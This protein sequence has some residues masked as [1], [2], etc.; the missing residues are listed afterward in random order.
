M[1]ATARGLLVQSN[2]KLGGSAFHFDLPPVR[3]CPGRSKLCEGVCYA[4]TGR[5]RFPQVRERL[6]WAFEQSRRADFVGRM[7]DELYRKGVLLMR[8]HVAGDFYSP[9]Y[10]KKARAVVEALSGVRFWAYTRSWRVPKLAD[11]LWGIAELDNFA[12]WLSADDETGYPPYVPDGVRVAWMQ[13]DESPEQADLVFAT[14]EVRKQPA[15]INL[16]LLCP[17]ETDAG[18]RAGTT[19]SSCQYC[20]SK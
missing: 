5:F 20:F 14:R 3:T 12:L 11:I 1:T 18:M 6:E 8:W 2:E 15:R 7:V 16:D 4:Q 17:T 13:T 9:D 10:C 19:C